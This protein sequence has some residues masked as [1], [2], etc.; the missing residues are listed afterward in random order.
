MKGKSFD[1]GQG[2][3]MQL[4]VKVLKNKVQVKA[5][6]LSGE[7]VEAEFKGEV[8][9]LDQE[10]LR[11][12]KQALASQELQLGKRTENSILLVHE[13]QNVRVSLNR[14]AKK[15]KDPL[16]RRTTP[17]SCTNSGKVSLTGQS[18]PKDVQTVKNAV[19][20]ANYLQRP[21]EQSLCKTSLHKQL[22]GKSTQ[23]F[24]ALLTPST[25]N[26]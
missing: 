15:A 5:E 11:Q 21:A 23:S 3:R 24:A 16:Q 20:L 2:Q 7:K 14:K 1:L 25:A 6:W 18:R 19:H 4:R 17:Q 22:S 12:I 8:G 26:T 9:F 13:A 10:G